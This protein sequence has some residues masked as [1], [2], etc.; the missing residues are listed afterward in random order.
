VN[1]YNLDYKKHGAFIFAVLKVTA[2]TR[3][4]FKNPDGVHRS[5]WLKRN[6][7]QQRIF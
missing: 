7:S 2:V 4:Y 3:D 5:H 6:L 1:A